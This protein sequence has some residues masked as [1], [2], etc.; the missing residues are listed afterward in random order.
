MSALGA[1]TLCSSLSSMSAVDAPVKLVTRKAVLR[2]DRPSFKVHKDRD[3]RTSTGGGIE[4]SALTA[5][6]LAITST[7][8]KEN[9]DPKS[10]LPVRKPSSSCKK[11]KGDALAPKAVIS[12]ESALTKKR[13]L[14]VTSQTHAAEKTMGHKSRPGNS[15]RCRGPPSLPVVDEESDADVL[16]RQHIKDTPLSLS[17]EVIDAH[18]YELTV[19]PLADISEA[20][21]CSSSDEE[22]ARSPSGSVSSGKLVF[23]PHPDHFFAA[24]CERGA[25]SRFLSSSIPAHQGI[26]RSASVRQRRIQA[27]YTREKESLLVVHLYVVIWQGRSAG[28]RVE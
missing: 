27:F 9:V 28:P 16:A 10:G 3:A 11:R 13:K 2:A 22:S 19:L 21:E 23:T 18:C 17:P 14:A 20:H 8:N 7:V 24:S 1:S 6:A 25:I 12:K 4:A 15:M 26:S 5:R